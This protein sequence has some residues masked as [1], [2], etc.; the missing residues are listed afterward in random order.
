M[1][2]SL[3][4]KYYDFKN[5]FKQ[6]VTT[7]FAKEFKCLKCLGEH[8]NNMIWVARGARS[9][10]NPNLYFTFIYFLRDT[11][12]IPKYLHKYYIINGC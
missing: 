12:I 1:L 5:K 9:F 2:W 7:F 8:V 10:E 6:I 3:K 4:Y 11:D